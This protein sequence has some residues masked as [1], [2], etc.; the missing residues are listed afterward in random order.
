LG[1]EAIEGIGKV[2]IWRLRIP[3]DEFDNER[4]YLSKVQRYS[5]VYD[6]V[7]SISHRTDY[8]RACL[9]MWEQRL[10]FGIY[11]VTNPGA[12]TTRQVVEAI[13]RILKPDRSFDFWEND[14]EFYAL[15]AK[16]R[17]SN[18]ILDV[19]KLLGCGIKIRPVEEALEDSLNRWVP[20]V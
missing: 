5:R 3:F 19:S 10:P 20:E 11:N 13:R 18:C 14:Q 4:N 2:Y 7:N 8:V 1:E 12:I 9:D 16:T 15:A 17:R 6:N